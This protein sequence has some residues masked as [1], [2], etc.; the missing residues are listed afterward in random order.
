M[1]S[2]ENGKHESGFLM[3]KDINK[4]IESGKI[5]LVVDSAK[6]VKILLSGNFNIEELCIG[7]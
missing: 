4:W 2:I 6:K 5:S 1:V 3:I 7:L